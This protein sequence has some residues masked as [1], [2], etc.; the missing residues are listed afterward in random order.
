MRN[1]TVAILPWASYFA[2]FSDGGKTSSLCCQN[3]K[4]RLWPLPASPHPHLL[5]FV[6][7]D[8]EQSRAFLANIR[9]INSAFPST[10]TGSNLGVPRRQIGFAHGPPTFVMP[11]AFHHYLRSSM[12]HAG[13][14]PRYAEIYYYSAE[15]E[16]LRYRLNNFEEL[17]SSSL[18]AGPMATVQGILS[19]VNPYVSIYR[20]AIDI[21]RSSEIAAR[22]AGR[23][24][25]AENM[26]IFLRTSNTHDQCR[27]NVASALME[28]AATLWDSNKETRG[29]RDSVVHDLWRD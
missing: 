7:G 2:P 26:H 22:A 24:P 17:S 21:Y 19:R 14:H 25:H 16:Q 18:L 28:V 10:S 11:V 6:R 13:H 27:Y 9:R 23:T 29:G 5:D 12:P 3:G 20:S 15:E 4:V 8:T 1:F